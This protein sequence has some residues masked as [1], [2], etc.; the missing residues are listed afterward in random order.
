MAGQDDDTEEPGRDGSAKAGEEVAEPKGRRLTFGKVR[1]ELSEDEL[2][3]SG[4]QKMLLDELDRMN[5]A[6][7]ELKVVAGKYYEASTKLAVSS[8]KLKT[9][10]GFDVISTGTIAV[11]SLLFGAAFSIKDNA[12]ML[13]TLI[14][15]SIVLVIIGIVA[16]VMRA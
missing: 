7:G 3:S 11:G 2:S 10:N 6:E 1:R 12:T 9:H 8:E 4:V 13:A 5:G 16:K 15:L 14:G